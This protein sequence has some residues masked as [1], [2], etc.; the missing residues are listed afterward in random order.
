MPRKLTIETVREC[1]E[2]EGY[3]LLNDGINSFNNILYLICPN[4]HECEIVY[5]RFKYK[6]V[7]C[8]KCRE[9]ENMKKLTKDFQEILIS[10]EYTLIN[11]E[12]IKTNTQ[13]N[14]ICPNNHKWQVSF[15]EFNRGKRCCHCN[16]N[17]RPKLTQEEVKERYEEF[18]YVL[19]SPYV[20]SRTQVAAICPNGHEWIHLHPNFQKGERCFHC[21]GAK[22]H[23]LQEARKAF[24]ERGFIPLFNEYKNNKE[25]LPFIC[26]KH[27]EEGTQYS[28]L[29]NMMRGHAN[30]RKC[31]AL[32]FT[33]ENSSNW[34]GGL[35]QI[36]KYLRDS[37]F[38]DW[39][40]PSLT[41]TD[42][43]C[44]ITKDVSNLV[45]HHLKNF[46]DIVS[47]TFKVLN[48]NVLPSIGDYTQDELELLKNKCL[49]LHLK[50]GLGVPLRKDVHKLFHNLYGTKNNT[51]EQFEEFQIRFN[52]GELETL[53]HFE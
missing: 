37:L 20:N 8:N 34:K 6:D 47:E 3:Q 11:K 51:K 16:P 15:T 29:S 42:Y 31:Y 33:G 41:S 49:E 30:C 36:N 7:R 4:N 21:F 52:N 23:S 2:K 35:T 19:L 25:R 43:K 24:E 32:L 39:V 9:N 14:V 12:L 45:V 28:I 5:K 38:N 48:L 40:K 27:E 53:F 1:V 22:K 10:N 50:Y 26:P 17:F 13:C 44:F 18:G 46:S